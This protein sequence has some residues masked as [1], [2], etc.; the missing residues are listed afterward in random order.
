MEDPEGSS[1]EGEA[2]YSAITAQLWMAM[3]SGFIESS[4]MAPLLRPANA[5]ITTSLSG[6]EL[7]LTV[8]FG[9][10]MGIGGGAKSGMLDDDL[11][12]DSAKRLLRAGGNAP[13]FPAARDHPVELVVMEVNRAPLPI[14]R[15]P[16]PDKC[17]DHLITSCTAVWS[18]KNI[19]TVDTRKSSKGLLAISTDSGDRQA[20]RK[21]KITQPIICS[22]SYRSQKWP[23]PALIAL[24]SGLFET[25]C[26]KRHNW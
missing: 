4:S 7:I 11:T 10:Q 12:D 24:I 13:R 15:S 23:S 6:K 14:D 25:Q 21:D 3:R 1:D 16:E 17:I 26:W 19:A 8:F 9:S 20:N 5:T 22:S 2:M 18:T